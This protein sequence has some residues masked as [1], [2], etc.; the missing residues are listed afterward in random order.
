MLL[1]GG[2]GGRDELTVA[3]QSTLPA[4]RTEALEGVH[5]ID[6]GPPV[7]TGVTDTVVYICNSK[8]EEVRL[9]D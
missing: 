5:A 3:A 6:T 1:K 8:E 9:M 4:V 7:S 2:G